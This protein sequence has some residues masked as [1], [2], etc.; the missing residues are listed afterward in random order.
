MPVMEARLTPATARQLRLVL[1]GAAVIGLLIGVNNAVLHLTTDPFADVRAYYDAGARLNAG[2]PLYL[3]SV[4]TNDA[5]FYRYPPLL[6]IAFRPL[7]LLP[8]PL[9]AAIWET[10]LVGAF[11]MTIRRLG[12][13]PPTWLAVGML[14]M[15][16]AWS[17]VIGQAQVLVTALLVLG[18]PWAVALAAH[19]KLLP[20]L[21]A[22]YWLGR[23]DWASLARFAAWAAGLTI[24]QFVLEP[25]ATVA[26]LGFPNLAQVG[27]VNNL[28]IYALSP[29]LWAALVVAGAVATFRLAPTRYGWA[30]AIALS[31][32][33]TPRLL[34]YQLS[35][36]LAGLRPPTADRDPE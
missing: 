20:A 4:G 11:A 13:R 15:P 24:V 6:A 21:V 26:F 14:A 10:F 28:S 19:L 18:A 16:I 8:W 27:A 5:A 12:W 9:A 22:I 25:A 3:Q 31:V 7:A 29:P 33:A 35:T 1:F 17:L 36:L 30:A 2:L 34:A 32:L 23:R